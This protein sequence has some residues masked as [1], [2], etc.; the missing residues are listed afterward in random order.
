M[1]PGA[2]SR[3]GGSK[4]P[5]CGSSRVVPIFWGFP[6]Q[7]SMEGLLEASRKGEV[8]LGGCNV[9]EDDPTR[10][11]KDCKHEWRHNTARR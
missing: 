3:R 1:T 2:R 7:D 4:C 6:T 11:C 5:R 10:H 8:V 9:S